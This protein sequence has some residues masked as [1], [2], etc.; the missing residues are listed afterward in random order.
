MPDQSIFCTSDKKASRRGALPL[1]FRRSACCGLK[2]IR[3][4]SG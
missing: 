1:T 3:S 2:E 4:S